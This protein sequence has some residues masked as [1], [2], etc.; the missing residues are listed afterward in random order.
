[1]K[2]SKDNTKLNFRFIGDDPLMEL[3][4]VEESLISTISAV[5]I[6]K[7]LETKP[8]MPQLSSVVFKLQ[9]RCYEW[10][11]QIIR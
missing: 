2:F 3:S 1:M 11:V 9:C 8:G 5:V 7:R 10:A 6:I 4:L